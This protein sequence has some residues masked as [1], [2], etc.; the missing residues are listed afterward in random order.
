MGKVYQRDETMVDIQQ[1][2]NT[3][4]VKRKFAFV[5]DPDLGVGGMSYRIKEALESLGHTVFCFTPKLFPDLFIGKRVSVEHLAHFISLQGIDFLCYADG[6]FPDSNEKISTLDVLTGLIFEPFAWIEGTLGEAS[7]NIHF[8]FALAFSEKDAAYLTNYGISDELL[9]CSPCAD[10]G[11][12]A[13]PIV[14]DIAYASGILCIQDYSPERQEFLQNLAQSAVLSSTPLYCFGKGWSRTWSH[15]GTYADFVYASRTARALI[16]FDDRKALDCGLPDTR[17]MLPVSDGLPVMFIGDGEGSSCYRE[18]SLCFSTYADALAYFDENGFQNLKTDHALHE[19]INPEIKTS[20]CESALENSLEKIIAHLESS[21]CKPASQVSNHESRAIVTILGYFGMGNFGDELILS[22]LD[23]RIRANHPGASICA[24]SENPFHTLTQRGIYAVDNQDKFVIDSLLSY[25]STALVV[26]GLLFDQGTRWTMGKAEMISST[27]HSDIPGLAGFAALAAMN[28]TPLVFYG[29]GAGPLDITASKKLVKL[30]GTL[31]A[32]FIVRDEEAGDTVRE[33]G[34]PENLI[35]VKADTA[36]L[37]HPPQSTFVENWF[38]DTGISCTNDRLFV[39][40]LREYENLPE[41]FDRRIAVAL[42][43]LLQ[44]DEKIRIA[45]CVLDPDD[46]SLLERVQR[47]IQHSDKAFLFDPQNDLEATCAL[48]AVADTGLAMRYHCSLLLANFGKPCAGIDYLP[49]VNALYDELGLEPL[50]LPTDASAEAIR[51]VLFDLA[52]NHGA[53]KDATSIQV[54]H[55]KAKSAEA[56]ARINRLIK[57][58][59][60]AKAGGIPKEF[61][62]RDYPASEYRVLEKIRETQQLEFEIKQACED[63]ER[64]KRELEELRASYSLRVGN[65]LMQIPRSGK[66]LFK[67]I[68]QR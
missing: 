49:K 21:I 46:R 19:K 51:D 55:L 14:N 44:H 40:S 32:T 18:S 7:K 59:R 41:D 66:R 65:A 47:F 43:S 4:S 3:S 61:F 54:A 57:E 24:V 27:A 39:V 1:I 68:T 6:F 37:C 48:L 15:G 35:E 13:S 62:L 58:Y 2:G 5:L 64:T 31:G 20:A 60:D 29:A 53:W 11:Y 56:E 63:T 30:M 67:R 50:L 38:A 8:S 33:C 9:L 42:G 16:V 25:S 36:F 23:E 45:L 10:N 17:M 52:D 34:V 28:E 26:A 12:K 22:M